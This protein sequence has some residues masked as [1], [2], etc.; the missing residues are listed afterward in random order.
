M[1][2]VPEKCY[3]LPVRPLEAL[4]EEIHYDSGDYIGLMD[5]VLA[6]ADWEAQKKDVQ[7]RR[8]AGEVVVRPRTLP[9]LLAR[10][11]RT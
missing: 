4:G 8:E 1:G 10:G 11:V 3:R 5:K 6:R 2:A 7:R 9:S